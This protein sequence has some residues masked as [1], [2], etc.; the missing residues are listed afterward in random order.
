MIKYKIVEE[1]L[2]NPEIGDYISYGVCVC[3]DTTQ[4]VECFVSDV[5]LE[6]EKAMT[7][8]NQCN[9]MKLEAVHLPNVIENIL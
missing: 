1:H 3:R 5:F 2:C 6:K 4:E 8:V 9:E 7:F